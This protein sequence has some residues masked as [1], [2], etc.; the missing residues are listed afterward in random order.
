MTHEIQS[1]ES[2]VPRWPQ[3]CKDV[4]CKALWSP[5]DDKE[6]N[7]LPDEPCHQ[8]CCCTISPSPS[9]WSSAGPQVPE[10]LS[11]SC[12][13]TKDLWTGQTAGIRP[14]SILKATTGGTGGTSLFPRCYLS[15]EILVCLFVCLFLWIFTSTNIFQGEGWFE[16]K[17]W[18]WQL[19]RYFIAQTLRFANF[20]FWICQKNSPTC[21]VLHCQA[22][23]IC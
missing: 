1:R 10:S 22:S 5:D 14:V 3:F 9:E 7:R 15:S 12:W 17:T 6:E 18:C 20:G 16:T 8:Q 13:Q 23:P 21:Q 2:S 19:A 11:F 4:F